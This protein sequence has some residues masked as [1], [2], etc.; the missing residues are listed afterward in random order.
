MILDTNALSALAGRDPALIRLL[1]DG[2]DPSLS[3]V[4][5]AEFQFGLLGSTRPHAGFELLEQ[6]ARSVPV[7]YPNADTLPYYAAI[8][9]QL[10]RAGRPIPHNDMWTGALARQHSLPVVSRD[11]HFDWITG[12]QRLEW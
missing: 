9:D 10:K 11:R 12:L 5:V 1:N 6:L 7:I 3:F 2:E 4:A 8:A